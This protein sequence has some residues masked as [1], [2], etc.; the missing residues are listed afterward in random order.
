[1]SESEYINNKQAAKI[2]GVSEYTMKKIRNSADFEYTR[3]G[4]RNIR[5][6]KKFFEQYIKTHRNIRY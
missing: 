4:A 2:L 3:L 6:S 1:M 5:I